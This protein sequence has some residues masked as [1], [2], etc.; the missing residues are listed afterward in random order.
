MQS[1]IVVFN[2]LFTV[3]KH[4]K[5]GFSNALLGNKTIFLVFTKK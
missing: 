3:S 1:N 4:D 2:H 5:F